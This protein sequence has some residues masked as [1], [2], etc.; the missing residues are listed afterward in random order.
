MKSL[1]IPD[2]HNRI[3]VADS[4]IARHTDVDEIVFLGDFFD[5]FDDTPEEA[6][7]TAVWAKSYLNDTKAVV[8]LG[9]HDMSYG[10]PGH[11]CSGWSLY[12]QSQIDS[13]L[14]EQSWH[15]FILHYWC[16]GW[17]CTHAGFDEGHNSYID[18]TCN[19]ALQ[20]LRNNKGHYLLNPGYNRGGFQATGG[21]NWQDWNDL[22][23]PKGIRQICGHTQGKEPRHLVDNKGEAWCIDTGLRHYGL[24][25]DG[26]LEI[27]ET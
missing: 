19:A 5:N 27:K 20:A 2:I 11:R 9:N 6:F 17:L 23:L 24:I 8:I 21:I 16:Q 10:F 14:T 13:V 12:K 22:A 1:I 15:R 25:V 18:A 26:E 7:T 3:H 4:I